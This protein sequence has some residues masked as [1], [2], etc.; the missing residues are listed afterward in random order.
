MGHPCAR[1]GRGGGLGEC[2]RCST[3]LSAEGLG[4]AQ[5]PLS[6]PSSNQLLWVFRLWSPAPWCG[7]CMRCSADVWLTGEMTHHDCLL[8]ASEGVSVIVTNHT[9]TE[10]G[11]LP[12][13]QARLQA[14]LAGVVP[15]DVGGVTV[16]VTKVDSDPLVVL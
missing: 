8:A 2:A 7:C 11:Y 1:M 12:H 14:A 3:V 10:R 5:S 6:V 16:L 4:A 15:A 13:L 9:N